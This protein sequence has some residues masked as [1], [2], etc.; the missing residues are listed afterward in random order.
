MSDFDPDWI[1]PP[2][3][4]ISDV[5]EERVLSRIEFARRMDYTPK[6]VDELLRGKAPITADIA[7]KLEAVLGAS[8]VFWMN[9][10]AQYR[11]AVARKNDEE[12]RVEQLNWLNELPVKDMINFGWI[13]HATT[14]AAQ[15]AACMQFFEVTDVDAWRR[16]YREVLEQ[17]AFRTSPKFTSQPGAVAAWLRKGEL[18]STSI[19]C[20]PWDAKRF[21]EVL[22]DIRPLTRKRD[23]EV[24]L[25]EL[26]KLCAECGV[27]VVIV[28]T[29]PGCRASGATRFLSPRKAL[30]L[31]SFRY[32]SDDHF[33]FTFFH[34]AGH[35]LLHG[36]R[37]LFLEVEKMSSTQEKE[38][39]AFAARILVPDAFRPELERLPV[40]KHAVRNFARMVGVSPGIIVGQLQHLGRAKP[41]Q[42]NNLKAR[43][44][45][46]TSNE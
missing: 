39:N 21:E 14:K 25:P 30:L 37:G 3:D 10:E 24:F 15:L 29:P 18:D 2:G 11:E 13:E 19:E 31:L 9:R 44:T 26:T 28:R 33:W 43:F 20:K 12:H 41:Y 35:L 1:S 23:P 7:Q 6:Q 40:E 36:E 16:T 38:A 46:Q 27:A 32:L 45:W 17:A 22:Q 42:L 34:E 4:T 5:L 8:A